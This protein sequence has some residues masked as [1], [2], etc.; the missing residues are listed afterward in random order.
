MPVP[1]DRNSRIALAHGWTWHEEGEPVTYQIGIMWA[2]DVA[3]WQDPTGEWAMS[4]PDFVGTLEGVSWMLRELNENTTEASYDW[5]L[6][7]SAH[8]Q[9]WDM[10]AEDGFSSSGKRLVQFESTK[11]EGVGIAIGDAYLL[12][13][14]KKAADANTDH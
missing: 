12:V 2:D 3:H 4:V 7:W 14:E 10:W 6:R 13:F 1:T 8:F 5:S 11:E 9:F